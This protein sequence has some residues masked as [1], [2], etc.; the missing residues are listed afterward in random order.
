MFLNAKKKLSDMR[1]KHI[2]EGDADELLCAVSIGLEAL[3]DA[4]H[5]SNRQIQAQIE[6]IAVELKLLQQCSAPLTSSGS[7]LRT[8]A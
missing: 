3:A 7:T 8:D 6:E 1:R 2:A 4:L 5:K